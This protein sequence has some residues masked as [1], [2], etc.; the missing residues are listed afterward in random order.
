MNWSDYSRFV[1]DVFGAPLAIEALLAF[2]LEST[3]L[4]LWIFGWDRLPQRAAPGLHLAGARSARSLSAYFILAAN[5][6]M[7]HP[8]G[9]ASTPR[10]AGPSSPTSGAVLTNTTALVAFPHT[11]AAAFLTG[12]AFVRRRRAC[13]PD[14]SADAPPTRCATV[15]AASG[16]GRRCWSPARLRGHRRPAGQ[17]DDRAAADEDGGGRGAVR[18]PTQPASF[19]L[20]TV[21][22]LDGPATRSGPST[23]PDLLSF[24]ATGDF[25]GTVEGIN[26]AAA[27]STSRQFGTRR[28]HA[29]SSRSTYW[30]PADDRLRPGRPRRSRCSGSV[31]D[32]AR[33][34]A[35][36]SRWVGVLAA[37]RA[38]AAARSLANSF[39]W[40]FTEMGR[41]PWVV[42]RP[43]ARPR[44]GVS[45]RCRPGQALIV[46]RS[47]FTAAVRVL[48]VVEVGLL[49]AYDQGRAAERP[50]R[51]ADARPA[52]TADD[53][54]TRLRLLTT[55]PRSR[56]WT[57]RPSGSSSSPCSGRLLRPRGL[58][59]RGRHAAAASSAARRRRAPGADQ[60]H[61][62][63]LG[64]QRG[65]AAR[66]RRRDVRGLPRVVRHAVRGLLPAAAADPGGADRARGAP[67]STAA[68]ATTRRWRGRWDVAIIVGSFVPALLWG[69]A[70]AQHRARRRRSTR[71]ERVRRRRFF[72][73]LNPTRCWAA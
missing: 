46:P 62:P 54:P 50:S 31:A 5:S 70:F 29:R 66:R 11:I 61:R 21:G 30:L 60:H 33:A 28:L 16:P 55:G 53:R 38:A 63:G 48:A 57:S 65:V 73:L 1:G 52:T 35:P 42:V 7:Q 18:R 41:Q 9:Y 43:D 34:D 10:P 19:S 32:P 47:S 68:S 2:F 25:D 17:G 56:P 23:I 24:L 36:T 6:W 59:L 26:D 27:S 45:P 13:A 72:D 49:R 3:F 4:G 14:R 37:G 22:T 20:F 58:R 12:G 40:I 64:R 8:V 51:R 67:S 69:V 44:D 71:N 15:A 39:G